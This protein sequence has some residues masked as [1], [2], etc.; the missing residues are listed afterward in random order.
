MNLEVNY[1]NN[2][3]DSTNFNWEG[4]GQALL[5]A[6]RITHIWLNDLFILRTQAFISI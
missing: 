2:F 6:L 5:Q 3:F 4:K 1:V